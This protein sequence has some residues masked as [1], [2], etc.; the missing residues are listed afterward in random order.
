MT[1]EQMAE[2]QEALGPIL[3]DAFAGR[4]DRLQADLQAAVISVISH[5]LLT[6]QGAVLL[7]MLKAA[8]RIPGAIWEWLST[9]PPV[10]PDPL[11]EYHRGG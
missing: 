2:L 3:R 7:G 5:H 4:D 8:G 10:E 6:S 1:D 11:E 9:R